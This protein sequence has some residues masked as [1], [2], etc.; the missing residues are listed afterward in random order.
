MVKKK[1]SSWRMCVD[2]KQLNKHIIKDKFPIPLIEELIDEL[3]GSKVFSKLDLRSSY[4]QI[5]MYPD[6]IAKTTFQTHQGYYEFLVMP[7]GLTNAL[8]TFQSLMNQVFKPY[9]RN[10]TLVFFD[11][12]LVYNPDMQSHTEHLRLVLQTIRH[13]RLKAKLSKCVFGASQVEYLGHVIFD[14]GVVTYPTKI[15]A[16]KEWPIPKNLKQ[17]RGFLGLTGYYRRFIK[18]YAVIKAM[19][20]DLVL[21]IPNFKKDFVVETDA[22]R[23]GIRVLLQQQ[24]HPIAYLS[25]ALYPKHQL[26]STYENE[27][28]AGKLVVG[29]DSGLQHDLIEYFHAGTM[30]GH[31]GVKQ[32]N[33][34]D[35]AASPGLLQPLPIPLRVWSEVSMDFIDGLPASKG[36]TVILVV[37]DRLTVLERKKVKKREEEAEYVLVQ[38]VNGSREDATWESL[39]DMASSYPQFS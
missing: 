29:N 22:S 2:Y 36:K 30:G 33:K 34:A 32:L 11:D 21:K 16:M 13:H 7:F 26:L 10:F 17:L 19:M 5:K 37:V 20:A 12:I 25:K 14:K 31:S 35:L 38:W 9:F 24:G 27:L 3:C 18:D 39:S 28:L 4:H 15:Q 6:D 1:D 8:S 23:E